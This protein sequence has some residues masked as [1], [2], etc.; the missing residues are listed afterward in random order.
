[1]LSPRAIPK[2]FALVVVSTVASVAP[3]EPPTYAEI[4]SKADAIAAEYLRKPGAVGLSIGVAQRGEVVVAKAYGLADAEFDVPADKDT[5]FRIGS[6]TKQFTAAAIMRFVEQGKVSLDDDL[7]KY[8]PDFPMQGNAVTVRQLLNHTSGIPSYT[9]L[10]EEWAKL[11]PLELTHEEMLAL[12]KG[13]PFDFKPGEKWAYNNTAYYMLGMIIEKIS[14]VTYAQHMQN[15]FFTPL[16]LGRTRYDSNST[17]MKNRAQGYTLQDGEIVNDAPLGMSQPYAAGS[18]VSTGED[19]VRWSMA[20]ASGKVVRP[21]SF[22]LMT[23]AAILPDG[24]STHYGFGLEVSEWEGRP[25]I[26]HGGGIFGFNSMLMWLP[27]EDLHIAVISNGEPIRSGRIANALA[28]AAVGIEKVVAA[29]VPITPE[30]LKRVIG[31]F[32]L[33]EMDVKIWEEEGKA[34]VQ[35]DGQPAFAI[36]WQGPE[37]GGGNEF[38]ASF[39]TEVRMV[40]ADDGQSFTLFQG[41]GQVK[42]KRIVE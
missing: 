3:A 36:Q 19:L 26:R 16:K 6:V 29:N 20:I 24:E 8:V 38:R 41:G 4:L 42:A 39:D 10:G 14:G 31:K 25:C 1:M 17:L 2:F 27:E 33:E 11:Q 35:A 40:F 15:E 18:L 37:V 9:S 28:R 7:G 30:A 22:T 12:V 13:K 32:K 34:M 21:E 23:T 5:M